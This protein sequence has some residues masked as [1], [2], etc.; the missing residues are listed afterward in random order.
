MDALGQLTG[1]IAHD[2]NNLL[3]AINFNLESLAEE[4]PRTGA[5][6][7]LFEGARVAIDQAHSL[8]GHLLAFARRQPLKPTSLD[9]NESVAQTQLMLRRAVPAGIEIETRLGRNAGLVLADRNQF[10]TALLNLALN[11]RDAMPDGGKLIIETSNVVL[12][13][14]YVSMNSDVTAGNYVMV[15]VT[16]S[17]HGIPAS[18]LDNVFEPFFTTKDVGKGSGLGLSQVYAFITSSGGAL[19][20]DSKPG[21][22]TTVR[23]R[24]PRS[25][26]VSAAVVEDEA[27]S[28]AADGQ[29]KK[30]HVLLV[31]DDREVAVL[32][33]EMLASIGFDVT[34]AASAEA[35]L[36]ALKNGRRI[37]I[38][39]SDVR[40][41][42]GMNGIDLARE[43]KRRRPRM[44]VVLTTGYAEGVNDA[45]REGIPILP[46][47]YQ[48]EAL[49]DILTRQLR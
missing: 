17:G 19:S 22:G 6:E 29:G 15:A 30:G 38:V 2:F 49:S 39:F 8:I 47:P 14:S 18:I 24:F 26:K 4:V 23:L 37:D 7:P 1:G 46:K 45:R 5:T 34:H 48:L 35:A 43:I 27:P 10:E 25:A 36:G 12:D 28:A 20:I 21:T 32:S 9:I 40:M 13:D 41:P 11:A 42:G 31:E 44:P 33:Q 16:D 3:L